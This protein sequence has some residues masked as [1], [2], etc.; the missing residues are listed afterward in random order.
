MIL[1]RIIAHFRKQEWTAIFLDFVI[2]VL[3][4]FVGLQVNTWNAARQ[5]SAEEAR[6]IE[7]LTGD[8]RKQEALLQRRIADAEDFVDAGQELLRL[9]DAGDEPP[10]RS[11]VKILVAMAFGAS[12]REAPP[13]SYEELVAS[14]GFS[15][16]GD[17][18]LRDALAQYGQTNSLW[19]YVE[20]R[21]RAVTDVNSALV[22]A[23]NLRPEI[24]MSGE[25]QEGLVEAFDYDWEK[26][27][28]SRSE[29]SLVILNYFTA[30]DR[31]QKDLAAVRNVLA[32]L[33][34]AP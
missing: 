26:L 3:G 6:I 24:T 18:A 21:S 11:R 19:S 29:L 22:R 12:V 10:D 8:F 17:I 5:A 2:V 20:G 25:L 1:R 32:V 34:P 27:E 33:E 7:R 28:D 14:G 13:A 23:L 16:L 9:I 31:H 15:R 4:V 30:L